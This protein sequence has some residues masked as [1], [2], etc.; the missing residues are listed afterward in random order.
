MVC[1]EID[2]F[3]PILSGAE[4]GNVDCIKVIHKYDPECLE[5]KS[6]VDNKIIRGD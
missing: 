3:N 6:E 5:F 4:M 1:A 2:G